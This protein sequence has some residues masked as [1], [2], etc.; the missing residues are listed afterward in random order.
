[1][2]HVSYGEEGGHVSYGEDGGQ[3]QHIV[4]HVSYD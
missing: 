1:M 3:T 4:D 2:D